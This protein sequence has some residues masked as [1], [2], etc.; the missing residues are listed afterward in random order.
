[1]KY[2]LTLYSI[3]LALTIQAQN[4]EIIT[5]VNFA[6][7]QIPVPENCSTDSEYALIDCQGTSVQWLYLNEEMLGEVVE[8]YV[9]QMGAQH[10]VRNIGQV[11][12]LS[13]GSELKG[14][15][16]ERKHADGISY[17]I[18]ASGIVNQ[19]PLLLNIVSDKQL[20]DTDDLSAFLKSFIE[21]E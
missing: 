12:I 6:G 15:T 20:K 4:N 8:Q 17:N 13:F 5:Q 7:E 9:T 11:K 3:F 21:I 10:G 14:D 19:Q 2:Y 1:M 16:F 18:L